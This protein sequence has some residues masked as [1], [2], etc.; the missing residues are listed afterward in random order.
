MGN[1][2]S[3]KEEIP[4]KY[5]I[6][7]TKKIVTFYDVIN[8]HFNLSDQFDRLEKYFYNMTYEDV[9]NSE[10]YIDFIKLVDYKDKIIMTIFK[11]YIDK[12]NYYIRNLNKNL[13]NNK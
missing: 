9:V 6:K 11:Q 5:S 7:C 3:V 10:N 1:T 4:P 2:Q 8:E 12:Y 13:L